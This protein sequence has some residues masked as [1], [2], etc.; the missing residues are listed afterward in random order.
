[1]VAEACCRQNA[2]V[3]QLS[4]AVLPTSDVRCLS[5]PVASFATLEALA[6]LSATTC[7]LQAKH[8]RQ[9]AWVKAP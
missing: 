3:A 7:V 5:C 2:S 9:A 8:P 6:K 4:L 1:M